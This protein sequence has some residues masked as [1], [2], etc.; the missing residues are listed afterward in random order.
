MPASSYASGD[1]DRRVSVQQRGS[2]VDANGQ[3]SM[4]WTELFSSWANIAPM[5]G[6]EM[7]AA[8]AINAESTHNVVMRWRPNVTAGMR[9]VYQGRVFNILNIND[10]NM[11]H[12]I[13]E[14]TCSEGLN[15]G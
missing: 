7:L 4:V 11:A 6:T 8:Q 3:Q 14:L 5:G 1:L 13:L 9:L 10:Q 12:Q 15:Q 2:N